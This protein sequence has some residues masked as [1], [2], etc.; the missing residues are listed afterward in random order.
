MSRILYVNHEVELGGAERSLLELMG[1]LDRSRFEPHVACS[2]EGPLSEAARRL[3]VHIHLVPM[4]FGGR[5]GK[6]FGLIR[7]AL[8]LRR[9]VRAAGIDLVHTNTL[10]GGYC[11]NLGARLAGVPCVWHVRD[12]HYPEAAKRLMVRAD[13]IV[14]NSDATARMLTNGSGR[15]LGAKVTVVYNGVAKEF[16]DQGPAPEDFRDELELPAGERVVGMVGRMDPLKGHMQFLD[17][18]KQVAARL[19]KVTFVI[20]GDVL[21]DSGRKRL[22]SYRQQLEDH[23]RDIGIFGKVLFLGER[24]DVP[25][26]L[27]AMDVVVHPSLVVESFGRT[28]AEA[29]AVGRPVVASNLG[30]IP[31]IVEDGVNG[32]LF[33]PGD[34]GALAARILDLLEDPETAT[35]M[36]ERG[37]QQAARRFSSSAHVKRV[38]D[39]YESLLARG[40]GRAPARVQL[41]D[42]SGR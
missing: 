28:L 7:A 40:T 22:G 24:D 38:Q 27:S 2:R 30:G 25:R 16:F 6:F 41:P 21:F 26:L 32:Y 9:L 5:I 42:V 17:A 4:L 18:A 11:G 39:L 20:I 23:A 31:E 12:L 19:D 13:R 3:G 29:H 35:R 10:I 15:H 14:V 36:G 34:A 37:R 33:E 8:R 1:G